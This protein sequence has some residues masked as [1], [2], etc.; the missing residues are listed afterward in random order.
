V[1]LSD[2]LSLTTVIKI[3]SSS[4]MAMLLSFAYEFK[5]LMMALDTSFRFDSVVLSDVSSTLTTMQTRLLV[6][7]PCVRAIVSPS[8]AGRVSGIQVTAVKQ[9]NEKLIIMH[10]T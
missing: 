5:D 4:I 10:L 9:R 2:E 6:V 1:S 3:S 7:Q 8:L